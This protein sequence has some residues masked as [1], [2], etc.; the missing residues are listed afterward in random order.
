MP[1]ITTCNEYERM[2]GLVASGRLP[3]AIPVEFQGSNGLWTSN[4]D[5]SMIDFSDE[6]TCLYAAIIATRSAYRSARKAGA[7]IRN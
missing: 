7:I 6:D 3:A 1:T 4:F 2:L 5:T